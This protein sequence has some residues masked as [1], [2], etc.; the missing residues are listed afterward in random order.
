[1]C[2]MSFFLSIF[3]ILVNCSMFAFVSFFS[4]EIV[5]TI[6]FS[7]VNFKK[8]KKPETKNSAFQVNTRIYI[9][10]NFMTYGTRRFN[11]ALTKALQ[12]FLS[13]AESTQFPALIPIS[14]RSILILSSYLRLHLTK[15]LF[16]VGLPVRIL[17]AFLPS[18][19]L[20]TCPAISIF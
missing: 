10:T 4:L 15:G 14:S 13:W 18:S 6:Y 9:L 2:L 7:T 17:K 3:D 1:M 5:S 19:I 20:A 16:L 11:V 8:V 12:E